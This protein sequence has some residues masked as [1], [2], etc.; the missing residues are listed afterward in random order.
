MSIKLLTEHHLE[1]LGLEGGCKGPLS[2]HLSKKP[3]C[4]KSHIA[5]Q[6]C[7]IV[8]IGI[9]S[10]RKFA[11]EILV[12]NILVLSFGLSNQPA[13]LQ[14]LDK[15]YKILCVAAFAIIVLYCD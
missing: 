7:Y 6:L 2:L 11:L 5:T 4:W 10:M 3:H 15:R 13:Q 14:R 1:L 8:H 12:L 9:A